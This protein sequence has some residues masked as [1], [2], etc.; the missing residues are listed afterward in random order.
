[1]AERLFPCTLV[2]SYAQPDW[3][4]DKEKLKGRFPP[5]VRARELWRVPREF[6]AEAKA[7]AVRIAVLEQQLAGL[8]VITDGEA[9]RESYSNYFANALDGVDIETPGRA[10][11]RSGEP[12]FV[13]RVVGP[14]RRPRPINVDDAKFLRSLTDRAIKITVPGPF[15]MSQQAQNEY[16]GSDAECAIAYAAALNEEIKDLHAAGVTVVSLDEPYMQARHEKAREYG[17]EALNRALHG[18]TGTTCVHICFGYAALIH[19]RP[20]A[21]SFL[22]ELRSTPIRQVSIETAQSQL[23]CKVLESLPDKEIV[24]GVLDLSTHDVESVETVKNRVRRALEYV[25]PGRITLAPDCGMKYLPRDVAFG[26]LKAMCQAAE[27]L[28]RE[29]NAR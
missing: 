5:R 19:H 6:L 11:D 13:P 3:L 18:V 22:P 28:R 7:D 23:D 4:M 20:E 21:Y 14:I 15:T 2:G 1:M 26:K 9:R 10:L 12:V 24:L 17:V 8:D 25:D 27:E 29:Y 16:Y